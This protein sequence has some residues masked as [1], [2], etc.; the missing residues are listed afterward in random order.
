MRYIVKPSRPLQCSD[1]KA[2]MLR[3][4]AK[5]AFTEGK[6]KIN[7]YIGEANDDNTSQTRKQDIAKL[8]GIIERMLQESKWK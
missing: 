5:T 1:T 4:S 7:R 3:Q 8:F 2:T 6:K